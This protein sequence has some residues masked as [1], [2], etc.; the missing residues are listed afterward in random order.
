MPVGREHAAPVQVV[1]AGG[2]LRDGSHTQR[3]EHDAAGQPRQH[4]R[5]QLAG[6]GAGQARTEEY[7]GSRAAE[8]GHRGCPIWGYLAVRVLPERQHQRLRE[9]DRDL[10]GPA[11]DG[12]HLQLS[13]TGAQCGLRS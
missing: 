9:G 3:V 7:G 6:G 4:F 13:G 5:D 2:V 12:S 10:S 8:L 1:H 11:G